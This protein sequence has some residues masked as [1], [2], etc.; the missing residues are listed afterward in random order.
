MREVGRVL[1][2]A[3]VGGLVVAVILVLAGQRPLL[4]LI[5]AL[6]VAVVVALSFEFAPALQ[7]LELRPPVGRKIRARVA[8]QDVGPSTP[9]PLPLPTIRPIPQHPAIAAVAS[10][11]V[12]SSRIFIDRTPAELS[13][14]FKG[15]TAVQ[16]EARVAQYVGKWLRVSGPMGDNTKITDSIRSVT[17]ADRSIFEYNVVRAQFRD[18]STI[19]RLDVKS[20]GDP[21][22]VIGQIESID[23]Q[24]VRLVSC[25]LEDG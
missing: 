2:W 25:E 18:R 13:A 5:V 7:E 9:D 14:E 11:S 12:S 16:G 4:V 21:I 1:S 22:R 17:F 15:V 3:I 8:R 20:I 23:I 19:E 10:Q 6:V 24:N